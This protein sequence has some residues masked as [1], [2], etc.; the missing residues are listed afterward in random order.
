VVAPILWVIEGGAGYGVLIVLLSVP[1][2]MS[3]AER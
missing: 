2:P 3:P 1:A